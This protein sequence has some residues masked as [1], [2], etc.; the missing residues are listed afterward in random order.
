M[1]NDIEE[2]DD[3][4]PIIN[5]KTLFVL[6]LPLLSQLYMHAAAVDVYVIELYS[7][8]AIISACTFSIDDVV[9]PVKILS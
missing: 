9:L 6:T 5:I 3:E 8:F 2:I 7:Q 1:N 4:I